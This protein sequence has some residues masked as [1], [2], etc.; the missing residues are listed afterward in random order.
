[1]KPVAHS[2]IQIKCFRR[3]L[4]ALGKFVPTNS[5]HCPANGDEY[6]AITNTHWHSQNDYGR[7]INWKFY[8]TEPCSRAVLGQ[9]R[10]CAVLTWAAC[11]C[12]VSPPSTC[13]AAGRC[14]ENPW[15]AHR[16][17][18]KDDRLSLKSVSWDCRSLA[19]RLANR[20]IPT[21]NRSKLFD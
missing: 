4:T 3:I 21:C 17:A 18:I 15:L 20:W 1:M 7:A 13:L 14:W 9:R 5:V 16:C 19:S 2:F 12:C 10:S 8:L 11:T 6:D